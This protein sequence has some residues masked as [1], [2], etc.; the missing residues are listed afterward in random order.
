MN[1]NTGI[2]SY[3]FS[4]TIEINITV[5]KCVYHAVKFIKG[6][7]IFN[8]EFMTV[9]VK[10]VPESIVCLVLDVCPGTDTSSLGFYQII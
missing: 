3:I 4:P 6:G 7:L 1:D 5:V 8:V 9:S 10:H 2:N